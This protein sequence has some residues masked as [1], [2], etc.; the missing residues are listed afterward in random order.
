[1]GIYHRLKE[2]F[3]GVGILKVRILEAIFQKTRP[4]EAR[5]SRARFPR[6]RSWETTP[7]EV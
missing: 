7:P 3:I 5:S 1:M 2:W 6:A 4:L